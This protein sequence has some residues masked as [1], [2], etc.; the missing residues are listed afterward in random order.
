MPR[1]QIELPEI[2]LFSA[3]IP[4]RVTDINYGGHVGNDSIL[5]IMHEA[6]VQFYRSRG[7]KNELN[8]EGNIGQIVA[9]AAIV[10]KSESFLGDVMIVQLGLMDVNKYGFDIVYL[11]NN[12]ASGKEIARGKTGVV[13]FDYDKRK[14]ASIPFTV[15]SKLGIDKGRTSPDRTQPLAC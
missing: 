14:V 1:I 9:D 6:R 3:E 10:Y 12:K 15:K 13:C 11:I 5:S 2:F 8:L 7:F 4:V